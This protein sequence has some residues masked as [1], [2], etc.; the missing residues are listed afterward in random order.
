MPLQ[1]THFV[2]NALLAGKPQAISAQSA[3]QISEHL[4]VMQARSLGKP[5]E[6][7]VQMRLIV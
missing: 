2:V 3:V 7:L 6:H 5:A 1:A 4:R